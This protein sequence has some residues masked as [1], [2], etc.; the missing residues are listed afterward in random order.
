[1]ISRKSTKIVSEIYSSEFQKHNT[2]SD[3]YGNR[4]TSSEYD[5]DKLYDFLYE[6][7]YDSWILNAI[8]EFKSYDKRALKE[9]IMKLH[10]G[11][12][13]VY[14]TP[15]WD[16]EQRQKLGQNIIKDLAEDI[17]KFIFSLSMYS[18][19]VMSLA[20]QLVSVLELDGYLFKDNILY[21]SESSIIDIEETHAVL[22]KLINDIGL[23]NKDIIEHHLN[24]SE[25]HYINNKWDDS[26]ANS[27]KFLESILQ[28]VAA[29]HCLL[30][31]KVEISHS[32][33]DKPYKV[34]D[35]LEEASLI[36]KKEKATIAEN[37][38]LLSKTGGH[39]Y[40]AEKD[41][42]RLLRHISLTFSEFILLRLQG[43]IKSL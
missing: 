21:F 37:Y 10:T 23:K 32:I 38:G 35:Y 19:E 1:M 26:I 41:Q 29:K 27:R 31:T 24:L 33:Y 14:L 8:K 15:D 34:R 17:L 12:S 5:G 3:I 43:Y 9:F 16:W 2:Y 42:A 25:E 6:N 22:S 28:E 13:T 11:E 36:E 18:T 7:N 30:N 20:K 39:P 4:H 40:I